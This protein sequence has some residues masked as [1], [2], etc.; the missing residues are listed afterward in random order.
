MKFISKNIAIPFLCSAF[1]FAPITAATPCARPCVGWQIRPYA[2]VDAQWR[3]M[4]Y[5]AGL[6]DNLFR[7]GYP[8]GNIYAG[9]RIHDFFGVEA[10]FETT[11]T[12]TRTA[13]VSDGALLG[14][15]VAELAPPT[16]NL[17]KNRV[18]AWHTG[19]MGYFPVCDW[20]GN[21]IELLGYV[22]QARVKVMY[23]NVTVYNANGPQNY[24]TSVRTFMRRRSVLK[25]GIGSQYTF[26]TSGVRFLLSYENTRMFNNLK[27]NEPSARMRL[28]MRNS[29]IYSIGVFV[30]TP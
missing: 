24:L 26:G 14:V 29:L 3:H 27:S 9:L 23:Q 1:L 20:I 10:G 7:N 8:Q 16:I 15:S 2:G 5:L 12:R 13:V 28:S 25:L 11:P 18:K 22:G 21:P 19:V 6:G 17:A 4:K 30:T